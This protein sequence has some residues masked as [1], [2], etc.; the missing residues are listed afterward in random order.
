MIG[1]NELKLNE[2]TMIQIVQEWLD[3]QMPGGAP[4]VKGVSGG[5]R[6]S[7]DQFTVRT[8]SPLAPVIPVTTS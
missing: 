4:K 5:M 1:C 8:E 3:R 6:N 7:E 2:A